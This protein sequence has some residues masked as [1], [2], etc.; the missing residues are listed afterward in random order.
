MDSVKEGI[1]L[2]LI[3][4]LEKTGKKRTDLAKVCGVG[5][6]AVSNW[7][8][9]DSSIDVER[10]PA[11]CEFFEITI[12]DFFGRSQQLEPAPDLTPDEQELVDCYRATIGV[13]KRA[14]LRTARMFR[15]ELAAEDGWVDRTPQ[16]L[17]DAPRHEFSAADAEWLAQEARRRYEEGE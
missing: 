6:S 12:D 2:N 7:V 14:I 1:R 13:G 3:E 16:E 15:D 4:L 8:N 10:I 9:G 5:K 17:I 11:I